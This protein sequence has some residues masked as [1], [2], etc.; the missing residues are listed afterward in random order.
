VAFLTFPEFE[1]PVGSVELLLTDGAGD[2]LSWGLYKD[3]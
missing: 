3:R 1:K 2:G